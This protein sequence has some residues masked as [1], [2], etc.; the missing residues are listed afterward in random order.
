MPCFACTYNQCLK[1][2]LKFHKKVTSKEAIH[3]HIEEKTKVNKL[4][5]SKLT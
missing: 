3:K 4:S 1:M 2:K 5:V